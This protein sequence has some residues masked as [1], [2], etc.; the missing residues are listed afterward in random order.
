MR[1]D[2]AIVGGG[3]AGLVAARSLHQ[4]GTE[5]ILLEARERLG[6][7]ILSAGT[8]GEPSDDGFDLGPSWFWPDMQPGLAALVRELGLALFT[9][10]DD[11]DI[12]FELARGQA[13]QRYKPTLAQPASMPLAGGPRSEERRVG[14]EWVR[15]CG[16]RGVT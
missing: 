13:P 15:T 1:T 6:G 7:R 10:P 3:L 12:L 5:F 9:Q 11:G 14:K 16:S 2:V 4:A 8:D